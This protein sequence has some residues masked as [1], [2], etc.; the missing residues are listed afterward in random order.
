M[1]SVSFY[2]WVCYKLILNANVG[3]TQQHV[4]NRQSIRLVTKSGS[5]QV[6]IWSW[7]PDWR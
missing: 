6:G 4:W 7:S 1:I 3:S 2:A 5:N